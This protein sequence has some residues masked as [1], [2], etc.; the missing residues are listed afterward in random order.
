MERIKKCMVATCFIVD[1]GRI[2]MIN[3]KGLGVWL[4]PG[5][6]LDEG[7]FPEDAAV[8]EV[9]EETGLEVE[10]ISPQESRFS[11][12]RARSATNPFSVLIEDIDY[13]SG[14]KHQHYDVV[15][16]AVK[17][18]GEERHDEEEA[19]GMGWFG[20]DQ[21]DQANTYPNVKELGKEA[22]RWFAGPQR[23]N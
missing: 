2:L 18:R 22:I 9:L 20:P 21:L 10:L 23:R 19:S 8:R 16:L 12:P 3:H 17:R 4:P 13:A 7:E 1:N 11:D 5:G 15:Y 6:H 14:E